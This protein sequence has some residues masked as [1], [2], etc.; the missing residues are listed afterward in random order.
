M[1]LLRHDLRQNYSHLPKTQPPSPLVP[2]VPLG[3][4]DTVLSLNRPYDQPYDRFVVP[5]VEM[6]RR[7][8][9]HADTLPEFIS[10]ME[11]NPARFLERTLECRFPDRARVLY[12]VAC[13]LDR[14]IRNLPGATELDRAMIW[15]LRAMP[16]DVQ[17]W[18]VRGFALAGFQYLRKLFGAPVVK[19]DFRLMDYVKVVIGRKA[20]APHQA[21]L[22]LEKAAREEGLDIAAVDSAVWDA[23][24]R[25]RSRVRQC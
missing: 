21:M 6:Y 15:A 11:P 8:H 3:V 5:R 7:Q 17:E 2:S 23:A 18:R 19:P 25:G 16:S 9:P 20:I 22:L 12:E 24:A 4:I 13:R 1:E 14:T 10:L